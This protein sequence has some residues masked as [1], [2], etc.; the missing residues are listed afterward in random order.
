MSFVALEILLEVYSV[1]ALLTIKVKYYLI[2]FAE[3]KTP[4]ALEKLNLAFEVRVRNKASI[5]CLLE[6][7]VLNLNI[8]ELKS[9]YVE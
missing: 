8:S 2:C 6:L 4:T 9:Y 1:N 7:R 5:S 3:I